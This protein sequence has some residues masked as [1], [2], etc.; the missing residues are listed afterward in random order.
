MDFSNLNQSLNNMLGGAEGGGAAV[1]I[2]ALVVV[3]AAVGVYMYLNEYFS[4]SSGRVSVDGKCV[5]MCPE[6]YTF[7][8][9]DEK[10]KGNAICTDAKGVDGTVPIPTAAPATTSSPK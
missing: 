9:L 2:L 10:T 5:N 1:W 7:K 6:G 8:S 4:C 3:L